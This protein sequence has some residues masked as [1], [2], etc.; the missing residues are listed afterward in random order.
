MHPLAARVN[1]RKG[2]YR[3]CSRIY[4]CFINTSIS[5]SCSI[6]D[7]ATAARL[8]ENVVAPGTRCRCIIEQG[9][10]CGSGCQTT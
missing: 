8:H 9:T 6:I 3:R 10:A 2:H 1:L 5:V 4:Q 7:S